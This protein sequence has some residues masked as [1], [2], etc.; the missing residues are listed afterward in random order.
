M[1]LNMT[2]SMS[3]TPAATPVT[4]RQE[5]RFCRF[6]GGNARLGTY[7]NIQTHNRNT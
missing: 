1:Q 5:R 3:V 2:T 4:M 7:Q 6:Q